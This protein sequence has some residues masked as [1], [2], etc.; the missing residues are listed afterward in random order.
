MYMFSVLLVFQGYLLMAVDS[1]PL[2]SEVCWETKE[3][4]EKTEGF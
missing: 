2:G 1:I 4:E 3:N